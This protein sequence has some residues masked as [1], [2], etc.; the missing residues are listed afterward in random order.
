MRQHKLQYFELHKVQWND[1]YTH[2]LWSSIEL[3]SGRKKKKRQ[4][5]KIVRT[6]KKIKK[7]FRCELALTQL[8]WTMCFMDTKA[9]S[10]IGSK[11]PNQENGKP[12]KP[13]EKRRWVANIYIKC[14]YIELYEVYASLGI[15]LAVQTTETAVTFLYSD[16]EMYI[17]YSV[18]SRW[19]YYRIWTTAVTAFAIKLNRSFASF[20]ASKQI[21]TIINAIDHYQ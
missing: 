5:C 11:L 1:H 19:T 20:A 12:N 14:A 3:I 10:A 18:Y 9:Q 16:G 17:P 15:S 4:R 13:K 6:N 2:C 8:I 21:K 7:L